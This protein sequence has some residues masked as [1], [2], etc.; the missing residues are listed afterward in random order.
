MF[1]KQG[2]QLMKPADEVVAC[3]LYTRNAAA[4]VHGIGKA[5]EGGQMDS[6]QGF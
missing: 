4:I 2:E 5:Q 1:R 6:H 3:R